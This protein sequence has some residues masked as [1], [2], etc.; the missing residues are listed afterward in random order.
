ME[1]ANA[2]CT[3]IAIMTKG[4]MRCIG[5]AQHLKDKYGA[6]YVLNIK[7]DPI[8]TKSDSV[9][10]MVSNIF[11][12]WNLKEESDDRLI[13]NIP[14]EAVPSLSAIFLSLENMKSNP[15][16][17]IQDY[18]FSQTTLEQVFIYFAKERLIFNV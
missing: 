10:Q 13:A 1:E 2:L 18:S 4:V 14:Q 17:G 12:E 15:K 7:W 9:K 11:K 5:S 3:R 16:N 8:L 6:G